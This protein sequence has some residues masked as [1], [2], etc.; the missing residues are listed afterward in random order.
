MT[1]DRDGDHVLP[2]PG[3]PP[4]PR[5][6]PRSPIRRGGSRIRIPKPQIPPVE[7]YGTEVHVRRPDPAQPVRVVGPSPRPLLTPLPRSSKTV[8]RG[9]LLQ[10][11]V[12]RVRVGGHT[13]EREVVHHPGAVA[14][15]AI[16][17]AREVVLVRQY[18]HPVRAWLWE[19]PAGTLEPGEQPLVAA[20]RELEEETGYRAENWVKLAEVY[21]TPGFCTEK[22]VLYL[23]RNLTEGTVCPEEDE[24]LQVSKVPWEEALEGI[25]QGRFRDAKTILGLV[26]ARSYLDADIPPAEGA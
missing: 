22:M 8:F 19:I 23:A 13:L 21:T 25:R 11:Q 10:V 2:S 16:T 4:H 17:P 24:D 7:P 9:K 6:C 26:L 1:T 18:R 15:V 12:D 3:K 5:E 20:R 14:V